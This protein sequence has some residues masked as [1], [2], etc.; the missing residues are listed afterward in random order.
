MDIKQFTPWLVTSF[1]LLCC[2]L[3]TFAAVP[4]NFSFMGLNHDRRVSEISGAVVSGQ[5]PSTFWVIND[6]GN[7]AELHAIKSNG[8]WLASTKVEDAV[9]HDWEDLSVFELKG[10][11]Y[12]LIADTGDNG[13]LREA[14]SLLIVKEPKSLTEAASKIE[15]R[16]NFR[17][18]EG[19]RD[20]EAVAVD[21]K[22]QY[23]YLIAKRHFP[24]VL[25]RL[26]LKPEP[27]NAVIVAKNIGSFNTLP[28]ATAEEKQQSPRFGRFQG[29]ITA[30]A[31]DPAGQF[32]L[33]LS[34]RDLYF[35]ARKTDESWL[36]ALSRMPKRMYL[37]LPQAEA[38]ALDTNGDTVTVF[39]ERLLAPI[40][41]QQLPAANA[42]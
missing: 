35:Y 40:Y 31:L 6:S 30:F 21:G 41:R 7:K 29:D 11:R 23:I 1:L 25:Y 32:A 16:I 2:C 36:Q 42:N 15:W 4:D 24:R 37:R 12:L 10:Q 26:P 28:A 20:I 13:G 14:L 18:P 22:A 38:L 3:G 19:A 33:V 9:N 8:D 27:N 39:S 17:L 5:N 34:Y